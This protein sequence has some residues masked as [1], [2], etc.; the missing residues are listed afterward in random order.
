MSFAIRE[1]AGVLFECDVD[2]RSLK[3]AGNPFRERD[4]GGATDDLHRPTARRM[5]RAIFEVSD[6][7]ELKR[8]AD[9]S[10]SCCCLVTASRPFIETRQSVRQRHS[11]TALLEEILCR[12]G[13]RFDPVG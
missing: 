1:A 2:K 3:L 9:K 6:A 8:G 7:C 10:I 11:R 5:R 4:G 13:T 12:T